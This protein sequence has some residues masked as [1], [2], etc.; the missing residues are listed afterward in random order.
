[1]TPR[2]D[3]VEVR[4]AARGRWLDLLPR[5]EPRLRDA[6]RR[7]P[8]HGPCPLHGGRDDFRFFK[9]ATETVGAICATCGV[10]LEEAAR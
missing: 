8:H 7:H 5:I 1:M 3:L 10:I 2:V 9:D 4:A 6:V